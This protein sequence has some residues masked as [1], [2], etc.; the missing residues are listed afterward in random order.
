[1]AVQSVDSYLREAA[2]LAV[3]LGA[4]AWLEVESLRQTGALREVEE[5]GAEHVH[6]VG[7][8]ASCRLVAVGRDHHLVE[9]YVVGVEREVLLLCGFMVTVR[10]AVLYPRHFT[11]MVYVPSGRFFRK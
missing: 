5:L 6:K 2:V 8:Q 10:S 7:R 3:V 11:T 9:S 1:M 4:H